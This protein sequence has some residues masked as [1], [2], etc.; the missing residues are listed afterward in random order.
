MRVFAVMILAVLGN[1]CEVAETPS[2]DASEGEGEGEGEGEACLPA[3]EVG[4][5]DLCG[6]QGG[7]GDECSNHDDGLI[8]SPDP[9]FCSYDYQPC[10]PGLTCLQVQTEW[11]HIGYCG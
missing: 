11:G 2:P 9:Y 3:H 1:A 6:S 4:C 10:G 5:P 7:D 8:A